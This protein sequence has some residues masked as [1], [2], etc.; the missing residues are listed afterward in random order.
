[1]RVASLVHLLPT[2]CLLDHSLG[3]LRYLG[4]HLCI[5]CELI[6]YKNEQA[7]TKGAHTGGF[8]P[9]EFLGIDRLGTSLWS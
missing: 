7:P 1:M 3:L 6:R 4:R 5:W 9:R 8:I 2:E